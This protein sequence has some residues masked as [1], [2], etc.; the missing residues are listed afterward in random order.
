MARGSTSAPCAAP[1]R[2]P[3]RA[4]VLDAKP[5][6]SLA[7]TPGRP[8]LS[9]PLASEARA[10]I[11]GIR[12]VL[13]TLDG[14]TVGEH[15]LPL[16]LHIATLAGA[17]V[18]LVH[19]HRPPR[20]ALFGAGK[21][22]RKALNMLLMHPGYE[23]LDDVYKRLSRASA[24]RI[25]TLLLERSDVSGAIYVAAAMRA[26]LVV[27]A[28]RA[29]GRWSRLVMGSIAESL[30]REAPVPM[31]V[32]RG[33]QAAVDLERAAAMRR[34]LVPL[35]GSPGAE[36]ILAPLAAL[37]E[38]EESEQ[39]LLRVL[40][41]PRYSP[42]L[43]TC[44]SVAEF[45][46]DEHDRAM[47]DLERMAAGLRSRLPRVRTDVVFSDNSPAREILLQAK[48]R[49]ADLIALAPRR[50]SGR[51]D[52]MFDGSVLSALVRKTNLPLLI[53]S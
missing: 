52:R 27:I 44:F 31:L 42:A 28:T 15:A 23:Y 38:L 2:T 25:N 22:R 45:A 12:R 1:V 50:R 40:P 5:H 41:V 51:L 3:D 8:R 19:V 14:T 49:S 36:R 46:A 30:A 11:T 13:V 21:S 43:N 37:G 9:P 35:D 47:C 17:E 48:S 53:S 32:V 20:P 10:R 7:E 29:R 4:V 6:K 26:D 18:E 33:T 16:A 39:T 34:A 24:V